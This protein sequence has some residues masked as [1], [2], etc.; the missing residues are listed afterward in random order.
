MAQFRLAGEVT[1]PGPRA[2]AELEAFPS[3]TVRA[4]IACSCGP[5]RRHVYSGPLLYDVIMAASPGFDP[6]AKDRVRYL[7]AVTGADGHQATL[8]WGEIDPD[9]G[10]TD[11]LLAVAV[12]DQGLDGDGPQLAVPHDKGGSRYVAQV[13]DIWVGPPGH[14]E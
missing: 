11:V 2:V 14:S 12:D 13:T 10:D 6:H 9:Y 5:P 7:V 1:R 8:S 3:R 4:E